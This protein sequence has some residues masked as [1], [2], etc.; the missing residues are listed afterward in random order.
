MEEE[1]RC[2]ALRVPGVPDGAEA[3]DLVRAE[4]GENT[5]WGALEIEIFPG[6]DET[7]LLA[8]PAAGTYIC[9]EALRFLLGDSGFDSTGT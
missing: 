5:P 4:L 8:R 3:A 9:A 7:L 2:L 1:R 6:R